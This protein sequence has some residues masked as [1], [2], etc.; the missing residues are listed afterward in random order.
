MPRALVMRGSGIPRFQR[1]SS[2]KEDHGMALSAPAGYTSSNLVFEEDFSGTTLDNYWHNYITS[3]AASGWPWNSY[4]SG[5]SGPGGVYDA[6]YDMPS[7]VSVSNGLLNLTAVKQPV[8]GMNQ[9]TAQ[10][11][12]ITSGAVSS[13]GNFEF[14]GGYLQISMKAP[15]GDGA[16]PGLWLLPGKGAGGSGDN[17]EIDM[18]EGG[19]T[20]SGP[21]NQAFTYHLHTPSGTFGGVVDTGIDLTAGFHTYG[22]N[23]VPG[24]LITWY[25]DGKQMAQVT[26]AQVPIPNEPMELIMSNQ[27]ANSNAAGWHTA[28]D[29]STSSSMPMQIDAIQLYQLP[30]SGDIVTGANVT[31]S[32]P[33]VTEVTASPATGIEHAGDTVTLTLGFN[34]AVT[35]TG[36]PTLVLNDGDTATYVSGS[37]TSALTFRTTVA[38]T[39][40]STSAL[41]ITG[42]NLPSGTGIRDASGVAAKLSGAVK[43]FTGLQINP[44]SPAVTQATASPVTG[45]EHVG[46][47]IT[48]TL[49]FNEAV[50]V[51]GTPTLSL[52]DGD[53][54]TYVSG[55]GT[56]ALTFRTTVASTDTNTSALAITGVNLPS[57]T[58]IKDAS[59]VAANLSGAVKTFSGL[60]INPVSPAVTQ[61]TASPVTGTEHL[62]DAITLTLGFNEA[63]T[64]TGTPTLSLNDGDTAIYVSGSGTSALTFRTTVASTDTS[65]SALAITGVNLPSGTSI[66]DVSGI[67]A[68]LSGAVKPFSGLQI[69]PTSP[70]SSIAPVLTVADPSLSVNGRGGTVDLG[71]K[72]STTDPNDVVT[73]N[74]TGLP[75]YET[76]VD[77]LDGHTF[78]GNN[79]TLTAA[80]VDSGLV[81][82]SNY[83][84]GGH[85]VATLTLAASAKD[86]V[87]SAVATAAPQTIIVTDPRSTTTASSASH[88]FALLNQ[89]R[90]LVT[91]AVATTAPQTIP[92]TGPPLATG[93]TTASLASQS[94]ALLNQCLA[95]NTGRVDPGQ[96]VAAVSSGANGNQ[97]SF[98]TRPQH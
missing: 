31:A 40:T 47:T 68:N 25:L 62:G 51:T 10:T 94:F 7:Q 63:V 97:D 3:N 61:A 48:L 86:P 79:V 67:A 92:V 39:D 76:I 4:G 71:V 77:S 12:P 59:G 45:I 78:K 32:T 2:F 64:V 90:D 52:S 15:S 19:Y 5:G 8:S 69:D 28:L 26:N 89:H 33:M 9:G 17:F 83:R 14:N 60:Q 56:S 81:L 23:W 84:G 27:V 18:Q 50:T 38:S 11:F 53:T 70:P 75:K 35:V 24:Q 87:T 46:D 1:Q 43:T 80:Q 41:A 42:V 66:K 20:G 44:L 65:T 93:K 22:I 13:Y 34:E 55:S 96:I 82:Q 29:S 85:P 49:G 54:A 88:S 21:A 95:G 91:G 57:G 30:G 72:V 98:L 73:V 58:G 16:W 74:I 37:G 6:D 36:T